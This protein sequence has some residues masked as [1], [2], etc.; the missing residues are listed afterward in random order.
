MFAVAGQ[1]LLGEL[2][3]A[4][5]REGDS[6]VL[7]TGRVVAS[8]GQT[9]TYQ[10][11]E[12]A[13]THEKHAGQVDD[14]HHADSRWRHPPARQNKGYR[15]NEIPQQISALLRENMLGRGQRVESLSAEDARFS[16]ASAVRISFAESGSEAR[17]RAVEYGTLKTVLLLPALLSS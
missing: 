8:L 9:G 4:L 11:H 1:C 10:H 7:R 14:R 2:H 13:A 17:K 3:A 16:G 6:A 12:P 15:H 5:Q